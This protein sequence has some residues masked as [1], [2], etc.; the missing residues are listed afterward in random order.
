MCQSSD[1]E[2]A[3]CGARKKQNNGDQGA[4]QTSRRRQ[5][6]FGLG[7]PTQGY[8]RR[9]KRHPPDIEDDS[10]RSGAFLSCPGGDVPTG[11]RSVISEKRWNS[12]REM[13]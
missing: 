7:N 9:R 8:H 2:C 1:G 5:A 10:S 3:E 13:K 6:C 12:R 4:N 11:A